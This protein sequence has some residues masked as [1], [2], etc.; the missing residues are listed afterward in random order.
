MR[1][2]ILILLFLASFLPQSKAQSLHVALS[3]LQ[4]LSQKVGQTEIK[5]TY[6]RPSIRDRVIFG[7]LEPYDEMW[8]TGANRNSKIQFS[9]PVFIEGQKLEKGTYAILTKPSETNWDVYFYSD[10]T[11]W[12]VPDPWV[13]S[14]V[15]AHVVVPSETSPELV[16][17]MKFSFD[18]LTYESCTLNF[19]WERTKFSIPIKLTTEEQLQKAIDKVLGG[20]APWDYNAAASYR[21]QT[22]KKLDQALEWIETA[23]EMRETGSYYDHLVKAKILYKQGKSS[24]G[25]KVLEKS[26]AIAKSSGRTYGI[27]LIELFKSSL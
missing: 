2:L 14:L 27:E 1:Y 4:V 10:T 9:H 6:S 7:G 19:S 26:L 23:I 16:Q 8:R 12:E 3:P 11:N 25:K 22:G 15:M 20:P 18:D 24:E 21:L 13:D 5:L 17:S